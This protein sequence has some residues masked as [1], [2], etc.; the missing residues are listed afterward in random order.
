[1]IYKFIQAEVLSMCFDSIKSWHIV[2]QDFLEYLVV[3]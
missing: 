2:L 3:R 1:M